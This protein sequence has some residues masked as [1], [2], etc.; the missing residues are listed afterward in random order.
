MFSASG[1]TGETSSAGLF[2][3]SPLIFPPM[4]SCL[5]ADQSG[6]DV[7]PSQQLRSFEDWTL[8]SDDNRCW[9]DKRN[10]GIHWK[11]TSDGMRRSLAA[12]VGFKPT[13]SPLAAASLQPGRIWALNVLP[14]CQKQHRRETLINA[15]SQNDPNTDLYIITKWFCSTKICNRKGE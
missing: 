6:L 11:C 12:D 5:L 15:S 3:W 2:I 8:A 14:V 9:S 7:V 13:N 10:D 1:Q 4:F